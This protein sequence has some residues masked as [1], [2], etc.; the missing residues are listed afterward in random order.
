MSYLIKKK[1]LSFIIILWFNMKLNKIVRA[2]CTWDQRLT[3]SKG[4]EFD[5]SPGIYIFG[6]N[7]WLSPRIL[8]LIV[9]QTYIY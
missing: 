4:D 6:L 7:T 2:I 1:Y 3:E 9:H 8:G 5:I